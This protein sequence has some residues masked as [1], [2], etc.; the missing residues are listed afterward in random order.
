MEVSVLGSNEYKASIE[1]MIDEKNE[2]GLIQLIEDKEFDPCKEDHFLIRMASANGLLEVVNR[3]LEDDRVDVNG[4]FDDRYQTTPLIVAISN[5]HLHIVDRLLKHPKIDPS[6][7]NDYAIRC[8]R[9][10]GFDAIVERLS[11]DTRVDT[12]ASNFDD[13]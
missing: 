6:A 13:E 8:A 4:A 1:K 3:L 9:L 11:Q 12:N 7:H 10:H 5:G 2:K